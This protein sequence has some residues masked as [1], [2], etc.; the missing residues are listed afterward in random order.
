M[1]LLRVTSLKKR[2]KS[3]TVV[4]DVS[5]QVG[6]GEVVGLLGPNGAGKTTCFYMIVGLVRADG[7]SIHLDGTDLT[8]WPIHKRAHQ[9]LS[10]LPQ[11]NSV[12]RKLTVAENILAVLELQKLGK[13]EQDRRLDELLDE[14][15][16]GHL[17][18]ATAMSLSGGERRRVE[19]ARALATRPRLILLDEPFAGVDPIAVLDIQKIISYLK[20]RGIGVLIT[21]HNV[22]ETLG[23]CDHAYIINLGEV[24]AGGTPEDIVQNDQVRQ[25]YLGEHFRL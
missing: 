19:I 21:D 10:Y 23:I 3:R 18:E 2:Y 24:L 22:R 12:F 4:H 11:E 6:S 17:R 13:T 5:F 7:G 9:G 16:I 8:H 1:S 14:L 20:A 25:V 15:N